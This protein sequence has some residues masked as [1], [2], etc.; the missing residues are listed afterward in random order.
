MAAAALV[1]T[2]ACAPRTGL[3]GPPPLPAAPHPAVRGP[4]VAAVQRAGRLRVAV[5]LS[6][7]SIAFRDAS[8]P[9]GFDVDLIDLIAGSLGVRAE[10]IDTPIAAMRHAFPPAID[11][12]AGALSADLVPGVATEPYLT[13]VPTIVWGART[14]GTTLAAL[15]GKRV[16]ASLG[17]VGERLARD[18][19]ATVVPTYL[20]EESLAMVGKGRVDAAIA[21]GP[22]ALGFISGRNGVRITAAGGPAASFVLIA[23]PGAAGLAA[24]ASAVIHDLRSSGGLEQL[25]RRWHL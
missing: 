8:G 6:V 12:A 20:P 19:G 23:R 10:F 25:R 9:A 1:L 7:S 21:D 14:S 15:R 13:A 3:Q 22:E 18:A 17:R 5:D 24:Y 16:A 11:L 4:A 2:A